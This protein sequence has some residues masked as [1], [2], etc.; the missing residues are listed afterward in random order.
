MKRGI[1]FAFLTLSVFFSAQLYAQDKINWLSIEEVEQK[2]K[3][4]PR[5]ILV[6]IYQNDCV[7]CKRMDEETFNKSFIADYINEH[8]YAISL[9]A[10]SAEDIIFNEQTYKYVKNGKRGHHE[11]AAELTKGNLSYPSVV[12]LDEDLEVLQSVSGYKNHTLFQ[13]IMAY[14]GKN[15]HKKVPWSSF[16]NT[17]LSVPE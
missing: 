17:I 2:L 15:Y 6:K 11:L 14:Y 13:Q 10:E 12:F 16:R 8:F 3:Q 1:F 7:W 9:N 4:E 5:K